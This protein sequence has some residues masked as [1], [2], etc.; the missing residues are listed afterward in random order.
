MKHNL[1]PTYNLVHYDY[2]NYIAVPWGDSGY[3][4]P[5]GR[6]TCPYNGHRDTLGGGH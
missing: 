6:D 3:V 1:F 2:S 4:D 5:T